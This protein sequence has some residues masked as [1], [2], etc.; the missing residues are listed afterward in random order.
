MRAVLLAAASLAILGVRP[1]RAQ[2]LVAPGESTEIAFR[3]EVNARWFGWLAAQEE[4]DATLARSKSEE[5][6]KIAEKIGIRRLTDLS[7]SATLLGRK[8]LLS[9]K[10]ERARIAF[11]AAIRLDPDLPEARW[12]QLFLSGRAK[13]FGRLPSGLAGAFR[14][15]LADREARRVVVIR[16][17]LLVVFTGAALGAAFLIVLVLAHGRRYVHDLAEIS[18]TFV[19]GVAAAPLSVL[20]FFLPLVLGLDLYWFGLVLFVA[21]FGYATPRQKVGAAIALALFIPLLPVVDRVAYEL[22]VTGSPILRGAETLQD[23][24]YDQRVLDDLESVKNVL[25]DDIDVRF[26]LGCLYQALGQNDRAVREYSVAVQGSPTEF[27]SLINRGNIHFVDGDFGAALEDYQEAVKRNPKSVA[28]RYNLSLVLAETF[29]TVEAAEQLKIANALDARLV[30]KYQQNPTLVKVVSLGY[31]PEEARERIERLQNDPRS[32][33]IL[34]H[35]R[36]Y[37]FGD[38]LAT[39]AFWAI[40]LALVLAYVLDDK[41]QKGR[42]FASECQKCG[43]TFCRRCKPAGQSI[44][45]CS[46]C[47]HVYLKKDGVAIETALQKVEEVKKRRWLKD[48]L[49][50]LLNLVLPGSAT[51]IDSNVGRAAISLSIFLFGVLALATREAFHAS[52]R[53]SA[54]SPLPGTVFWAVVAVAGWV[55]GVFS[56][57]RAPAPAA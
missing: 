28:A 31:T 6:V 20:V 2:V 56:A 49:R 16:T 4:G 38:S 37:H 23:A 25:A 9:G 32:H 18:M 21:I 11:E 34:G 53:P 39:P 45:L 46:Q 57:R 7:L 51:F 3:R 54:V 14:A 5:L 27:R 10:L 24:R 48:K 13:E 50:A 40:P 8:D 1:A 42:G 12:G 19:G 15:T 41:R 47:V 30:Q 33:R 22:A 55:V 44:L 26:L 35:Y 36:T 52:S 29:R 17:A 43:R